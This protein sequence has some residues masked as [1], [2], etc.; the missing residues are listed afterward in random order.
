MVPSE[1][2]VILEYITHRVQYEAT[3]QYRKWL[4]CLD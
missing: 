1:C 2:K 4:W 3:L